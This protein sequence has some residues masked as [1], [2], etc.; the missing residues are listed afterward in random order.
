MNL[1]DLK[2]KVAV[3]TGASSGL[4]ADAARAYAKHGADVA[5]LARRKDKL[6]A[7]AAE[8]N[9]TGRK[10]IAVACDVTDEENIKSAVAEVL[11][12]YGKIDIL[13]N[14]AGVAVSGTVEQLGAAEWDTEMGVNVKG[15]YLMAKY[16][17]PHMRKQQYGKIVNIASINAAVADKAPELARHAYNTSKAAV[18]GLTLG[19]AASYAID[20]I[21]VNCV[22][23]G[24]FESEM[25]QNTLFAHEGFMQMYNTLTP[26][27]RPGK[28]GELNGT[29][30]YLSSDASSYVTGQFILVDGG[31][32]IV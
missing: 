27:G 19:M 1:F 32:S 4:G 8:I 20:N 23:P 15:Y 18:K 14:N 29:L 7:L 24:L 5:L 25:T 13:L 6:E 31:F 30:M 10:A 28:R 9:T 26:A 16:V 21:T 22:G 11:G 3:I 17:V 12:H 2:G